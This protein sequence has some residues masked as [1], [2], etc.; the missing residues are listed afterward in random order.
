METQLDSSEYAAQRA[1]LDLLLAGRSSPTALRSLQDYALAYVDCFQGNVLQLEHEWEFLA[2]VLHKA[3]QDERYEVVVRLASALA[4]PAGRRRDFTEARRLLHLGIVASRRTRDQ[5]HFAALL[6][7]LG[8]LVFV[9]GR[10]RQGYRLWHT[11]LYATEAEG[12]PGLWEPLTSFAQ[13]ADLL[14]NYASAQHFLETFYGQR[15]T[16]ESDGLA[17]ALFVRGLYARF[18][19]HLEKAEAD[20]S[21][22]LR[23]LAPHNS[24]EPLVSTR[25]LFFVVVQA[26]LARTQG[27][28]ARAQQY[29]E[30][31]LAL[32]RAF[33]DHYTSAILLVDQG[34]FAWR[35]GWYD[36]VRRVFPSL[37]EIERQVAFPNVAEVNRL[38]AQ[39]LSEQHLSLAEPRSSQVDTTASSVYVDPLSQREREVLQLV[40]DGCSS[41][42]I[43]A[44]LVITTAT[45]KKHLEHIYLR[46]D[47]HNRTSAVLQGRKLKIIP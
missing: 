18:T 43:A 36:E 44:R 3:W 26:E 25:L 6:N 34:I 1:R 13:I 22:C 47:V 12:Q 30:T 45:V 31:A 17:V 4:Y 7:R 27:N 11:G 42:E 37:R 33:G 23:V 16:V 21:R 15:Q 20:F 19:S 9:H 38:L 32:A 5:H 24:G 28:Y 8:G 10:Y 2:A 46:L 40:A 41:R 39:Q 14:G 35:Q 29:S